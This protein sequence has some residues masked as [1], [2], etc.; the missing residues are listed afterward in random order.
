[1]LRVQAAKLIVKFL[2][3]YSSIIKIWK[4][5]KGNLSLS[6][7]QIYFN[8]AGVVEDKLYLDFNILT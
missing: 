3:P 6:I 8:Q 4:N 5:S 2:A 1:V 7:P